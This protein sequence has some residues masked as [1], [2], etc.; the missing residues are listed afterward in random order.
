MSNGVF[1]LLA[2][3]FINIVAS[4]LT[5]TNLSDM[6]EVMNRG[7]QGGNSIDRGSTCGNSSKRK[8][9]VCRQILCSTQDPE[10][11][12]FNKVGKGVE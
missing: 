5:C 11:F 1:Y 3:A 10:V 4:C 8:R 9:T 7:K 2:G 12:V 6:E